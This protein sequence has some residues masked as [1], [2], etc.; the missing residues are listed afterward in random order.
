MKAVR[1]TVLLIGLLFF[2]IPAAWAEA[3]MI[4][5]G[6]W[7]MTSTMTM[8]MLSQPRVTTTTECIEKSEISMDDMGGEEMDPNCKIETAQVDVNT[9]KWSFD[10]P[11]EGGTSHGEWEAT[12][13]GDTVTGEGL[14]T[15]SF[16]GQTME[17]T[18]NWTGRRIGVCD[19]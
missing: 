5:P 10:C 8:P 16:Q 1:Y 6:K 15:V 12:S 14:M 2:A 18:M 11:V 4:E 7:E 3:L 19:M 13:A 17:M 9:I